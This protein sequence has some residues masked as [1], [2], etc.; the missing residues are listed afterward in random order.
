MLSFTNKSVEALNL[1]ARQIRIA[2]GEIKK[3][4]SYTVAKGKRSFS[5]GDRVYF[6]KNDRSLGVQNGTLGT[7]KA[8]NKKDFSIL[9]DGKEGRA[10]NVNLYDYDHLDHGYAATI[11]KSQGVTVDKSYVLASKYFN[12]HLTYVACT[13]HRES[14]QI[15]CHQ[16]DFKNKQDFY[17]ALSKVRLKSMA[18]DFATARWIEPKN[19]S[20]L[21][22]SPK[23]LSPKQAA[24]DSVALK[25]L[26][27]TKGD[28]PLT[29]I[30]SFEKVR[31]YAQGI[32]EIS[33][34]K[35]L[36]TLKDDKI[37]ISQMKHER[38]NKLDTV[39]IERRNYL[40]MISGVS[41]TPE[42]RDKSNGKGARYR[43]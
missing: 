7:I 10:V 5:A 22:S 21:H 12:R 4:E 43:N 33:G 41:R 40:K 9:L 30:K 27:A 13:R 28:K 38:A 3:G 20:E 23:E 16:G 31:G 8:I 17:R 6:L 26:Q 32:V 34:K 29:I 15:F 25:I 42:I 1:Q 36:A 14:L 24:L 39:D 11:H 35:V 18:V 2:A 19:T 37:L